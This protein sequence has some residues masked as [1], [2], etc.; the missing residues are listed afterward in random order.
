MA[1]IK[2]GSG[3]SGN[4]SQ[5]TNWNSGTG[6]TGSDDVTIDAAGSYTV[7]VDSN[8][9]ANSLVFD[10]PSATVNITSARVLNLFHGATITGGTIDGPGTF[11]IRDVSMITAGPPLTLGG[12]LTFQIFGSISL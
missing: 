8:F 1:A 2:W 5:A 12:G 11:T 10:A 4:W 6:P 3:I 7:N 9:N